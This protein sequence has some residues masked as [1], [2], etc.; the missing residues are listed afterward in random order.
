MRI[1]RNPRYISANTS[2]NT[3]EFVID[4]IYSFNDNISAAFNPNLSDAELDDVIEECAEE[5][6]YSFIDSICLNLKMNGFEVLEGP[7]YSD[8]KGSKSCYFVLCKGDEYE[9]LTVKFILNLRISDHRLSRHKG[10]NKNWDRFE[11]REDYYARE[12]EN[13]RE[14]NEENPDDLSYD[15]LE[16]IVSGQKFHTFRQALNYVINRVKLAF[17]NK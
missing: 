2:S 14:L 4:M 17:R 10:N 8:R 5:Q 6:Y 9:K 15:N 1:T 13:Y 16:I 12:L 3:I 7:N 11:A